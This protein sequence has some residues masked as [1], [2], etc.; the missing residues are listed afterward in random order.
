MKAIIYVRQD[1]H[2]CEEAINFF[3]KKKK[4][5]EIE[6]IDIDLSKELI[7]QYNDYVPVIQYNNQTFYAPLDYKKLE[8]I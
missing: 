8:L 7:N 1:C 4:T 6:I 3:K 2:L 5:I